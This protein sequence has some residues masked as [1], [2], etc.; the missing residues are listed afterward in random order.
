MPR[1]SRYMRNGYTYH[2][3]HRCH[4]RRFLLRFVRDRDV[5]RRWL[6]EAARRYDVAVYGYCITSNHVHLV[7]HADDKVRIGLMMH[8]VAGVFARQFNRRKRHDGSVWEH[9]YHCTVIQDGVHLINCLC[10]VSLNMVRTGVVDHP[11]EWRWS[12]HDELMGTR[13]RYRVVAI[14]RLLESL[15]IARRE[16]FLKLYEGKI[17]ELMQKNELRREASWTEAVAIGEREFVEDVATN[18]IRRSHFR[19]TQTCNS[20]GVKSWSLR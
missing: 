20:D 18:T 19:Y 2:L 15:T 13:T 16:D 6:R 5:Y 4:D 14:D 7:V 12:A 3:T 9:P 17:E 10:Y 11:Q 8:L 1:A